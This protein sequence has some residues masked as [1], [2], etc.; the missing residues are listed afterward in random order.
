[1]QHLAQLGASKSKDDLGRMWSGIAPAV[2]G[3]LS[4]LVQSILD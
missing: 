1:M 3:K 4:P 2:G